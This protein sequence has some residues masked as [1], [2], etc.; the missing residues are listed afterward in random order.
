[1]IIESTTIH[2]N[3]EHFSVMCAGVPGGGFG[4]KVTRSSWPTVAAAIGE[5]VNKQTLCSI[6]KIVYSKVLK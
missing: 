1:M 2:D 4:G 3:N 6:H 5:R